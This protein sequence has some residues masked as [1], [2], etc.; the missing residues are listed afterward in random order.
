MKF[1]INLFSFSD[2]QYV[3]SFHYRGV[4]TLSFS[5][6]RNNTPTHSLPYVHVSSTYSHPLVLTSPTHKHRHTHFL[7]LF[8][9]DK[10]FQRTHSPTPHHSNIFPTHAL[11]SSHTHNTDIPPPHSIYPHCLPI[12]TSR[13]SLYQ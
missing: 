10:P 2:T 8:Q 7:T 9:H 5:Q 1:G 4:T 13:E 6:T 11:S 12:P 3:V